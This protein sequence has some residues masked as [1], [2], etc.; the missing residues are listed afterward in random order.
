MLGTF[1]VNIG[2]VGPLRIDLEVNG[3]D[4]DIVCDPLA[5]AWRVRTRE[6]PHWRLSRQPPSN[7]PPGGPASHEGLR[8][9]L[10]AV[11]QGA[12]NTGMR[13]AIIRQHEV[14]LAADRSCETGA[15]EDVRPV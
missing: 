11:E 13:E 6:F 4:G 9:F 12:T 8:A 3:A 15:W 5:G 10:D 14:G 7:R 2:A 1:Q